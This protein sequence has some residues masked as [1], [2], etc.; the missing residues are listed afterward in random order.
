[1]DPNQIVLAAEEAGVDEKNAHEVIRAVAEH[2]GL[3]IAYQDR[4]TIEAAQSRPFS[5]NEWAR[6]RPLVAGTDL[7][8]FLDNSGAHESILAWMDQ[9]LAAAGVGLECRECGQAALL[10]DNEV[11]HHLVT[12]KGGQVYSLTAIDHEADADHVALIH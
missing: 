2:F 10:D 7:D 5:D 3:A 1:M 8:E 4:E 11:S 9:R 12:E 6:L